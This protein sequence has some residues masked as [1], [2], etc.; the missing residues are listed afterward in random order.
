MP[1][2]YYGLQSHSN[3]RWLYYCYFIA[4]RSRQHQKWLDQPCFFPFFFVQ[5]SCFLC[6]FCFVVFPVFL[7]HLLSCPHCLLSV[8]HT[9]VSIYSSLTIALKSAHD[10][11]KWFL[12]WQQPFPFIFSLNVWDGSKQLSPCS[13]SFSTSLVHLSSSQQFDVCHKSI[14]HWATIRWRC[15]NA[16]CYFLCS[17]CLLSL[18]LGTGHSHQTFPTE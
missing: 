10:R 14:S 13:S 3:A 4:R 5:S 8:F 1:P 15:C 11:E 18:F 6:F 9:S 2:K 7:P 16:L 17:P 12:P